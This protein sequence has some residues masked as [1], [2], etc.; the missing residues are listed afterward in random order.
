[1]QECL[2]E[3]KD[4]IKIIKEEILDQIQ[5]LVLELGQDQIV[6]LDQEQVQEQVE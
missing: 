1:M 5:E 4:K 3:Y 2:K 6:D